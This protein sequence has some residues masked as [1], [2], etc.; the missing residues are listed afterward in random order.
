VE[1]ALLVG[2]IAPGGKPIRA[3]VKDAAVKAPADGR[4]ALEQISAPLDRELARIGADHPGESDSHGACD[5]QKAEPPAAE[6]LINQ[7]GQGVE[8]SAHLR[9]EEEIPCFGR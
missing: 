3:P 7:P 2:A 8:V 5:E 6:C 1:R 9:P 4:D